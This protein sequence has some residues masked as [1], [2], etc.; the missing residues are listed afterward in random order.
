MPDLKPRCS[1]EV[2]CSRLDVGRQVFIFVLHITIRT[3]I[4][5]MTYPKT[6][7]RESGERFSTLSFQNG[8]R[9]S[10]AETSK[11]HIMK[12][13]L[14]THAVPA[15]IAASFLFGCS[16]PRIADRTDPT[17]PSAVQVQESYDTF[18][19]KWEDQTKPPVTPAAKPEVLSRNDFV[20]LSFTGSSR[21]VCDR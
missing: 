13:N 10:G 19:R 18:G 11:Q 17:R 4:P 3:A 1:R 9:S 20:L 6:M 16:T 14:L 12:R 5:R 15:S 2:R 21:L 8:L 7:E